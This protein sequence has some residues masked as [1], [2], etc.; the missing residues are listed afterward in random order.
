MAPGIPFVSLTLLNTLNPSFASSKFPHS[1]K[2]GQHTGAHLPPL[3]FPLPPPVLSVSQ[4]HVPPSPAALVP[5]TCFQLLGDSAGES[6]S[7][8]G[9]SSLDLA[10]MVV[11]MCFLSL[12]TSCLCAGCVGLSLSRSVPPS[13][14]PLSSVPGPIPPLPHLL[15]PAGITGPPSSPL[16]LSCVPLPAQPPAIIRTSTS[17]LVAVYPPLPPPLPLLLLR[18]AG[19]R[20]RTCRRGG[21]CGCRDGGEGGVP[22]PPR[23]VLAGPAV[24]PGCAALPHL[25]PLHLHLSC[26]CSRLVCCLRLLSVPI[27]SVQLL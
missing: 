17:K 21:P 23:S 20:R 6:S 19:R 26:C 9:S 2:N 5:A 24:G 12:F 13:Y 16:A 14:L 8:N 10:G 7:L 27:S 25:L 3:P 18:A 22:L 15:P 11:V 1:H 4:G